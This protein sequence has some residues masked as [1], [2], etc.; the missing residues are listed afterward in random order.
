MVASV[1]LRLS[2]LRTAAIAKATT[3]VQP[4]NREA[5]V[6]VHQGA[7]TLET[8]AI[9]LNH[10]Y[11]GTLADD[12]KDPRR[13]KFPAIEVRRALGSPMRIGR[14]LAMRPF[15]VGFAVFLEKA[16]VGHRQ[17]RGAVSQSLACGAIPM[18]APGK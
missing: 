11:D 13:L 9:W 14:A 4:A 5:F 16:K 12:F 7:Q 18:M 17:M 2:L 15:R 8:L 1:G 3:Q 10:D 6:A